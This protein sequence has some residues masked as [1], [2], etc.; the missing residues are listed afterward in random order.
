MRPVLERAVAYHGAVLTGWF[1]LI[2]ALI[3]ERFWDY[4]STL[5]T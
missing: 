1:L 3:A 2:A 5:L 4:W